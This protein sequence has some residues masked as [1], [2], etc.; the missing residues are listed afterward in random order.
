MEFSFE[1]VVPKEMPPSEASAWQPTLR[2]LQDV[3]D[4]YRIPLKQVKLHYHKKARKVWGAKHPY[5]ESYYSH[6]EIT[7]CANDFDTAL[8]ELAHVW[9]R[10]RHTDKWARCYLSLIEKYLPRD[11]FHH[12]LVRAKRMYKP[13][14][15]MAHLVEFD[16]DDE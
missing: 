7:L 8:H 4:R 5:G 12:K 2:L 14:L 13:C 6:G 11:Q 10:A 1:L 3:I 15:R 9:A 16:T